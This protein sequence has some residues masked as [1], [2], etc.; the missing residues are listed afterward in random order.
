MWRHGN[1]DY[2]WKFERQFD[3]VVL[4]EQVENDVTINNNLNVEQV[5]Q[6][7]KTPRRVSRI[8]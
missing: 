7:F 6:Q 1:Y 8:E 5:D 4:H 2:N 3:Q